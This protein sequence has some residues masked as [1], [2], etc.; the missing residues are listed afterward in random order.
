MSA[1]VETRCYN[2]IFIKKCAL[3]VLTTSHIKYT[4][5]V[6]VLFNIN[7]CASNHLKPISLSPAPLLSPHLPIP[8][9]VAQAGLAVV[10]AAF[11][12]QPARRFV[13]SHAGAVLAEDVDRVLIDDGLAVRVAFA[14]QVA[15]VVAVEGFDVFA[16]GIGERDVAP[17][18]RFV[19]AESFVCLLQAVIG[20]HGSVLLIYHCTRREGDKTDTKRPGTVTGW[21][22]QSRLLHIL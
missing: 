11:L 5:F 7:T 8:Y 17:G 16:A 10:I 14:H 20:R 3:L 15:V 19:K 13:E 6:A 9:R 1:F 21:V 18:G 22:R 2:A 12:A 4:T